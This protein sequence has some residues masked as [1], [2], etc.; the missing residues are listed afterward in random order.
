MM[1]GAF[2][3][4]QRVLRGIDRS[5]TISLGDVQVKRSALERG[6]IGVVE[7]DDSAY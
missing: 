3:M 7:V 2:I 5:I 6:D 1:R 4:T